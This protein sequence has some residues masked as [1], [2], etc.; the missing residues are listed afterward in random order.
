M[1]FNI[2]Y[3]LI[4]K[5]SWVLISSIKTINRWSLIRT[6][7]YRNRSEMTETDVVDGYEISWRG[8]IN[9]LFMYIDYARI[10]PSF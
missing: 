3:S 8:Y 1:N 4:L 6:A 5:I 9:I 2:V 7:L 10:K